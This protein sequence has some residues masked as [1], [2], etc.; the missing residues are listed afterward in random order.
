MKAASGSMPRSS[1][2]ADFRPT[3]IGIKPRLASCR[4]GEVLL[5][6]GKA[7]EIAPAIEIPVPKFETHFEMLI[8]AQPEQDIGNGVFRLFHEVGT[9]PLLKR[10][11]LR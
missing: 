7:V 5:G 2:S 6:S 11:S 1:L 10:R 3:A 8:D 9:E 4:A